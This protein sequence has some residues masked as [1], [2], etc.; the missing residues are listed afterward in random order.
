[1]RLSKPPTSPGLLVE[2]QRSEPWKSAQDTL[3]LTPSYT[4]AQGKVRRSL[5]T[6]KLSK[7][8]RVASLQILLPSS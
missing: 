6:R 2:E 8:S 7:P 4:D 3:L 5:R 1:M